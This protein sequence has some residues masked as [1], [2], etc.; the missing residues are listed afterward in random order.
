MKI[1]TKLHMTALIRTLEFGF[2][3]VLRHLPVDLVSI[4]GAIGGRV[5][6]LRKPVA[7]RTVRNNLRLLR[8]DIT[9]PREIDAMARRFWDNAG[10]CFAEYSALNRILASDRVLVDGRE[11][12]VAALASGKP[13]IW[14]FLH[15]GN[16]EILGPGLLGMGEAGFQ[17][18]QPLQDPVRR[19]IAEQARRAFACNLLAPGPRTAGRILR[20]LQAGGGLSIAVDEHI[21]GK[22]QAPAFGRPIARR[23]NLGAAARFAMLTD[24]QVLLAYVVR[25]RG[26]RFTI[27]IEA[28]VR[29]DFGSQSIGRLPEMVAVLNA[30]IEPI[31]LAHIDQ[32]FW[33]DNLVL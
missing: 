17:I 25:R 21:N 6:A 12:L 28:P 5:T 2:H 26:A 14:M 32:W 13:R 4:I 27:R 9:D 29:F 20:R 22:V 24:A 18:Y 19:Q 10:R 33:L 11:H 8:P 30:R 16:W 7:D 15:L 3:H 23:C 31:V 1:S